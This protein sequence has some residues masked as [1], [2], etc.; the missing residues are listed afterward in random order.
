MDQPPIQDEL[1]IRRRHL[2]HW[3][4]GGSVYFITF[5]SS[6]G[7]LPEPALR[8]VMDNIRYDHGKRYDLHFAVVMPDHVHLLL[9]PREKEGRTWFDL[10]EIMKGIKGVS[11]RRINQLLGTTGTVWQAE[12][13]DR[14]M[15][16]EEEYLQK[17]EYMWNNAVKAGLV[18]KAEQY[19][20]FVFPE[21]R[22]DK[23]A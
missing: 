19:E 18:E 6:R 17:W 13:F 12:S 5:R 4:L 7:I 9:Q 2:P 8:Q 1:E 20:F 14:I 21:D 23:S 11:S 16:N 3:Q 15:R 22:T 10:A